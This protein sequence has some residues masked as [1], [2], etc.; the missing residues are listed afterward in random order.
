M[1]RRLEDTQSHNTKWREHVCLPVKRIFPAVKLCPDSS[2]ATV[3]KRMIGGYAIPGEFP[4]NPS[5]LG[6]LANERAVWSEVML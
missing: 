4:L 5:P 3:D 1:R 2:C 6:S